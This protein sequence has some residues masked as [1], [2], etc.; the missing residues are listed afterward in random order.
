LL[1]QQPQPDDKENDRARER[2]GGHRNLPVLEQ[3]STEEAADDR[4]DKR[5]HPCTHGDLLHLP[6]VEV[7]SQL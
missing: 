7:A 5:D 4:S 3:G 2:Y 1:E 6:L